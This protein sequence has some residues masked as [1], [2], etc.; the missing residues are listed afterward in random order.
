MPTRVVHCKKE[1]HD[2]YVGRPSILGNPFSHLPG[3][4]AVYH[5]SS[6]EEAISMYAEWIKTQPEIM[7]LVPE[8]KGLTLGCWCHPLPCH[9]H[10][11]AKM[12]DAS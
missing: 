6:R 4:L 1:K 10:A 11:L 9:A 12:A 8:L 3:T 7:A 5:V 2:V